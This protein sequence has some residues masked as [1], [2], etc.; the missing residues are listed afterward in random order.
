M[1]EARPGTAS[2]ADRACPDH[3]PMCANGCW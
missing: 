1:P 3:G 2:A